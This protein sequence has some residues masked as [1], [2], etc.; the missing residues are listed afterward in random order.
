MY[1]ISNAECD[2]SKAT[3][4][5]CQMK[6]SGTRCSVTVPRPCKYSITRG[7]TLSVLLMCILA[8]GVVDHTGSWTKPELSDVSDRFKAH[9]K[10]LYK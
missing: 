6:S 3:G 1:L 10:D 5:A 9:S 4:V 2:L 8:S 7:Q